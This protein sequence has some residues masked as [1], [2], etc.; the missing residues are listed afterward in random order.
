MLTRRGPVLLAV[1][2]SLY[3]AQD[4]LCDSDSL[5]QSCPYPQPAL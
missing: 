1:S 4:W 3:L 5:E 2:V